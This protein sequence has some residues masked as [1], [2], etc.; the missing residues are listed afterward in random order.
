[1]ETKM[2]QPNTAQPLL[3]QQQQQQKLT[4]RTLWRSKHY[5]LKVS[6]HC[7]LQLLQAGRSQLTLQFA[8]QEEKKQTGQSHT[9]L[10]GL[11]RV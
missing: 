6:L 8:G 7:D 5:L 4:E 10:G 3:L 11:I 2:C 9:T 1:M